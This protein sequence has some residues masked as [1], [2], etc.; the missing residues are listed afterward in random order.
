MNSSRTFRVFVS[1]T[2]ADLV[3]ERN[4]LQRRVWP[5]LARLCEKA[6]FRFQAIDLRWGVPSEAAL[7]QRT[8]R[9]CL[10]EL[11]RCQDTSPRPN[12]IILL[13]NRYGWRPLPEEIETNEFEAIAA[14][15]QSL[16][17]DESLLR[18]WYRLDT[19]AVPAVYYLRPRQ[20]DT[21]EAN[22]KWWTDN[23]EQPLRNL[24]LQ[25]ID[26]LWAKDDPRRIDYERSLTEREI[27]A[28]ALNP[29]ASDA[30][31][32]VFSYFRDVDYLDSVT[33]VDEA[34]AMHLR[35]FVDFATTTECDTAA[36]QLHQN[37]K[38]NLEAALGDEHVRKFDATWT[39]TTVSQDHLNRLCD[40]VLN[41]LRGV[42][43]A[44]IERFEA[45]PPLQVE[46][47]AHD[48]FARLRGGSD[49]NGRS[50]FQGRAE[51]LNV[52]AEYVR[53]TETN[54]P[55]VIYGPAGSGKSALM[56]KAAL[57]AD[58]SFP[59]A[60]RLRRFIGVTP[61]SVDARSLLHGL[62]EE[63]GQMF[64]NPADVPLEYREL[65]SAF[66]ERLGWATADRPVVVF[67]DAVDQL[68]ES[69]NARSLVWLPR[70]LPPHVRL[71]VSV[72]NDPLSSEAAPGTK[73][74]TNA[75]PFETLKRR[76]KSGELLHQIGDY[77]EHDAKAL[78][79]H[80]LRSDKRTLTEVQ[81]KL[82]LDAFA[83]CPRPLFLKLAAEEAKQWHSDSTTMTMPSA[84]TP[85]EM[86][87]AIINQLFDR[88]SEPS[89]HGERLV[90]RAIGYLVASKNGLTEDELLGLIS[91]DKEFFDEFVAR[92]KKVNQPLPAGVGSLPVAVWV[93]LYSDLQ[94]YLT[95]RRADGTTLL[96]FYHRILE[97]VAR[98]RFLSS[99]EV[100]GQRHKHIAEYFTP[101]SKDANGEMKFDALGF[102]RL[103]L[104]EQ[105]AWAKKL[106]PEPRPVNIR[107]VMELPHQLLE[108]A[109]LLGKD[110]AKSPHWDA[111]ADLLLNIHFLE[112]K[113]ESP[114]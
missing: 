5:E 39:G 59:N 17:L 2:F 42:I 102:F 114:S 50:R 103:T 63:L 27:M 106:P 99:P 70:Q 43:E 53:S 100:A 21:D 77:P 16:K 86:L 26:A 51:N 74:P 9:I 6:G 83:K 94:P 101:K 71:V 57:D 96:A 44:E 68:S 107:M 89:N 61:P 64:R 92:A 7:D 78:L 69:D 72:L 32:H 1:S 104:E 38:K 91:T 11:K 62:C 113:V 46:I 4:A 52:I 3:E 85:D 41:D 36:R 56:A 31:D 15:A 29:A 13:G 37:L 110:D 48:E 111:V 73:S 45:K 28:G 18:E 47:A 12:F 24:F 23:V 14:K 98:N 108:V 8:S 54:R 97:R 75:D 34:E 95:T 20:Q 30:R 88:L 22:G 49:D 66:R 81:E 25:C 58:K 84:T 80:W 93:R 79:S 67:L 90:E 35:P 109:K 112:A 60:V 33:Q 82:V 105:R 55:L 10:D 65:V 76:D 87:S 19:N 40:A